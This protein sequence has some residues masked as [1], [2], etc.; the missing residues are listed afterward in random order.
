LEIMLFYSEVLC[1]ES[2]MILVP[3][4][5]GVC[6]TRMNDLYAY[7]DYLEPGSQNFVN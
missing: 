3:I 1:K 6:Y 4:Y 2:Y 7:A 5:A